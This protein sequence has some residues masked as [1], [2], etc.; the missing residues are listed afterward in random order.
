MLSRIPC[1][2]H[3]FLT[4]LYAGVGSGIATFFFTSHISRSVNFSFAAFFIATYGYWFKC[5]LDWARND[6]IRRQSEGSF[7]EEI[8]AIEERKANRLD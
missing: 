2:K 7:L 4:G 6:F 5:R 8:K 3:S 1:F